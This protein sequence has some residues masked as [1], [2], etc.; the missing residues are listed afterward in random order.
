MKCVCVWHG[1]A[2]EVCGVVGER[3]GFRFYQSYVG[4]VSVFGLRWC[5][6]GMDG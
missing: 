1:A 6:G 2:C 3:I 5:S 4:H